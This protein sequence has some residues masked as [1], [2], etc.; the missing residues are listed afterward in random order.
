[1]PEFVTCK[2]LKGLKTKEF[3]EKKLKNSDF[4][5]KKGLK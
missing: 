1:M 4:G 3:E 2:F 5:K